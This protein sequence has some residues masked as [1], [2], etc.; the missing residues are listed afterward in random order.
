LQTIFLEAGPETAA[1]NRYR[2]LV[3]KRADIDAAIPKTLIAQEMPMARPTFILKRGQYDHKGEAV[4]RHIPAALGSLPSG[5][6][7]NRLGLADWLL[8]SKNP[9]VSRVFVNRVWQQCLGVG[10]VKTSEDFGSQGEW[11]LNQPLLDYLAVYFV[12]SGWSVKKLNR[13]IVTSAAFRQ[14]SRISPQKLAKDAENRLISRGPRYRLDAEVI[15][16]K[17]LTAGGLLVTKLGGRGFKPYQPDGLWESSSDPAS[18]TH[19]YKRD[20]DLGIY[21]RSMYLFWKRTSPPP[22]MVTLDAPLRDTCTVRR[23]TTNTPLQALATLNETAFLE[24]SRTMAQRLLQQ[25][26]PD[27]KRLMSAFDITLA[28]PPKP[29]ETKLL[30]RAL[31]RYRKEYDADPAAAK[32]LI[33]VGDAPLSTK[34]TA[35]EEASWMIVCSSLMNT[36]E[37]L[38]LH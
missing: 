1:A 11:P 9:L 23:S 3:K 38:T 14:S 13:M 30:L 4:E 12:Q 33:T 17:A 2:I 7:N 36:D 5:V 27:E 10:I 31:S 24:A 32:K 18:E 28:R 35:P 26:L 20:H 34:I 22:V 15:R 16:D 19:F 25:K 21:R 37:F 8:S 29:F 6:P